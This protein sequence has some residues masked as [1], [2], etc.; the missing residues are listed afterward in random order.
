[1]LS[2]PA[3]VGIII[4]A[5]F[6]LFIVYAICVRISNVK[7]FD[8]LFGSNHKKVMQE[9]KDLNFIEPQHK[10]NEIETKIE[11]KDQPVIEDYT[12]DQILT[13]DFMDSFDFSK[14]NEINK[15][16]KSHM[17]RKYDQIMSR[18]DSLT[19][20]PRQRMDPTFSRQKASYLKDEEEDDDF[21]SFMNEHSYGRLL[22][23]KTLYDQ[24]Q[25]LS[26]EMKALIFS[27]IFRPYNETDT[28][29]V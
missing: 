20:N 13:N 19:A 14:N 18:F 4:G 29:N 6:V 15:L 17:T 16:D 24:I 22:A 2:V 5:C 12:E 28:K 3:I 1:M 11:N 8:K 7:R 9:R 10:T 26:P 25:D 21:E 23:D 27:G